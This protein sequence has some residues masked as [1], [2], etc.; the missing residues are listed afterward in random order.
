MNKQVRH[1][2]WENIQ[3]TYLTKDWYLELNIVEFY[4]SLRQTMQ[5]FYVAKNLKHALQNKISE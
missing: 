1:R 5:F 4:N 3:S 2:L